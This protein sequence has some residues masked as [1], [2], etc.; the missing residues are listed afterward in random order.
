MKLMQ[1]ERE[2][3]DQATSLSKQ[4]SKKDVDIGADQPSDSSNPPNQDHVPSTSNLNI[5]DKTTLHQA[6]CQSCLLQDSSASNSSSLNSNSK[7]FTTIRGRNSIEKLGRL[8]TKP[9]RADSSPSI[10]H[11]CSDK[12]ALWSTIGLQGSTLS[13][14]LNPI[15]IDGYVIGDEEI[16]RVWNFGQQ[17][18]QNSKVGQSKGGDAVVEEKRLEFRREIERDCERAL[19]DRWRDWIRGQKGELR[20]T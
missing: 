18:F 15:Y 13:R 7:D 5:D 17:I 14:W 2:F 8:R 16:E 20:W 10:S 1:K 6:T 19:V 12:L 3:Q 9:G 11:S 4:S